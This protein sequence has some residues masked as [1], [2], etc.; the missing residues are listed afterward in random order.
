M[1]ISDKNLK[2]IEAISDSVQKRV[3]MLT[4]DFRVGK[5]VYMANSVESSG[6]LSS[7]DILKSLRKD[8]AGDAE[9]YIK[10]NQGRYTYDTSEAQWYIFEGPHWIKAKKDEQYDGIGLLINV[11]MKEAGCQAWLRAK[12]IK[13]KK[14]EEERKHKEIEQ[15]LRARCGALQTLKRMKNVLI[16]SRTGSKSLAIGDDEW[17]S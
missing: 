7:K 2:K 5:D 3:E 1:S 12:A 15:F 9:L 4:K 11:Y 13:K 14:K 10:M 16:L 6:E 8:E 17:S